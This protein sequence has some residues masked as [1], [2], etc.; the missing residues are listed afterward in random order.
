MRYWLALLLCWPLA[1]AAAFELET[2][3]GSENVYALEL[4]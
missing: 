4:R 1:N 3:R 2:Q